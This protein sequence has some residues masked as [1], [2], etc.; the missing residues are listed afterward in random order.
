M[1]TRTAPALGALVVTVALLALPSSAGAQT[2][3]SVTLQT[4]ASAVLYGSPVDIMGTIS[5]PAGGQA[6]LVLDGSGVELAS[7]VTQPDGSFAATLSLEA[8]TTLEAEWNGTMSEPVVVRVRAALTVGMGRVRLFDPTVARGSVAPVP[9]GTTVRVSLILAGRVVARREVSATSSGAFRARLP[10]REP[11]TYRV[12]AV[13]TPAGLAR[14]AAAAGPASTALPSLGPGSTGAYVRALEHRLVS[15][16]YRLIAVNSRYDRHTADAVLAFRKV[17]GMARTGTVDA[18]VWRRLA[19]PRLPKPRSTAKAFHI[20]VDQTRQVLYT[21]KGGRIT[22]IIHVS[23]G[24][25]GATR[26]GSFHVYRKLAGFSPNHLYYP[27]Y[28]DGLRAIHGWTE[29]PA[30]PAS[31]GCVRVPYWNAKWIF[32]LATIGTRVIVYH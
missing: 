27:N 31:H 17:Q 8:S 5:P 24:A 14:G 26:D 13:S 25:S 30:Y 3:N 19:D 6:V 12:R 1:R 2:T 10:V 29:V 11:G 16:H 28:F 18:A 7:A 23:T 32:G 22:S 20:E 9:E 15:L 21:V 4:S